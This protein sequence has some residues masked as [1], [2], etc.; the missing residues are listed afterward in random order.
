MEVASNAK[1]QFAK[2]KFANGVIVEISQNE[3]LWEYYWPDPHDD[4]EDIYLTGGYV[5]DGNTVVDYD[6]CFDLPDEVK[7]CLKH[8]GYELDL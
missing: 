2:F 3:C 1:S 4:D 6:G 5:L 7:K 8:L